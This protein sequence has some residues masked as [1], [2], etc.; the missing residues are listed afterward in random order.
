M[1]DTFSA[2]LLLSTLGVLTLCSLS[3]CEVGDTNEI[4]DQNPYYNSGPNTCYVW[5]TNLQDE[6]LGVTGVESFDDCHG[7]AFEVGDSYC[8]D[9]RAGRSGPNPIIL[10]YLMDDGRRYRDDDWVFGCE[11]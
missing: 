9:L 1:H 7:F 8:D 3:A 6:A 2:R 4:G 5:G 10:N 11:I